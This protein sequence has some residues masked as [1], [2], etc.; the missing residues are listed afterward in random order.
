MRS[1]AGKTRQLESSKVWQLAERAGGKTGE[2]AS[3]G[4]ARQRGVWPRFSGA[5]GNFVALSGWLVSR[6]KRWA[7]FRPRGRKK[8]RLASG[9]RTEVAQKVTLVAA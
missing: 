2:L 9:K 5:S 6:G 1:A 7:S 8:G 3:E 4:R